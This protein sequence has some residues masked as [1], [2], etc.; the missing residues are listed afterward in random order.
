LAPITHNEAWR[1]WFVENGIDVLEIRLADLV[2]DKEGVTR[3][4]SERTRRTAEALD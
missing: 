4:I 3:E 2:R 1:R